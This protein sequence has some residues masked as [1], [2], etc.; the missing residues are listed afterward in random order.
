MWETLITQI[1]DDLRGDWDSLYWVIIFLVF[2]ITKPQSF[3]G[4]VLK[5]LF[6]MTLW[7]FCDIYDFVYDIPLVL[8]YI[9]SI[10]GVRRVLCLCHTDHILLWITYPQLRTAALLCREEVSSC[11]RPHETPM[12]HLSRSKWCCWWRSP[13]TSTQTRGF[14][15]QCH[16]YLSVCM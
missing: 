11:Q 9:F 5:Y 4:N 12:F 8:I 10:F 7:S 16:L 2:I 13:L 3:N 14:Q 1:K 6:H 15:S